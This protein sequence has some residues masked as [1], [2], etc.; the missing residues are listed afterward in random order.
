VDRPAVLKI[1]D[2]RWCRVVGA[3]GWGRQHR[4]FA[5]GGAQDRSALRSAN[6]ILGNPEWSPGLE[7]TLAPQRLHFS[8]STRVVLA[9]APCRA[10]LL[11]GGGELPRRRAIAVPAGAVLELTI[12]DFAL[13]TVVA[14]AGGCAP[15]GAPDAIAYDAAD[16]DRAPAN[17]PR[18]GSGIFSWGPRRGWLRALPGPEYDPA[19]FE[20]LAGPWRVGAGSDGRALRLRGPRIPRAAHDLRSSG[21]ADG[22]WQL[23]PDGPLLL[24]RDRQTTGGYPRVANLIDC[25]VDLAAQLRPGQVFRVELVDR[26]TAMEAQRDYEATLTEF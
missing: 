15:G 16:A 2:P 1:S 9:G 21:V 5:P 17:V 10:R 7:C 4:G 18:S 12:L 14:I 25:D 13:R 8:R 3:P 23:T 24:L 20:A 19:M 6:R 26:D 11:D 22:T